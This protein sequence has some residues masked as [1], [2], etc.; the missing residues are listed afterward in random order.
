MTW[1]RYFNIRSS[2]PTRRERLARR[3]RRRCWTWRVDIE[4]WR[5]EH[6]SA[7]SKFVKLEEMIRQHGESLESHAQAVE[8]QQEGLRDHGR[9]MAEYQHQGAGERLQETM[10]VKHR[11][12]AQRHKTV[13]EAHERM[14]KHHHTVMAHLRA[15]QAAIEAA[16]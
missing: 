11:E 16:M 3:T 7:L 10:A 1:R 9:A 8:R 6:E 5:G 12:H 2:R 15:L 13:H 14:K 4:R